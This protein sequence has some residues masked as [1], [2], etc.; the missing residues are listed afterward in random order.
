LA[1]GPGQTAWRAQFTRIIRTRGYFDQCFCVR[2]D[3]G[4]EEILGE[5]RGH[6][7]VDFPNIMVK[8]SV[9]IWETYSVLPWTGSC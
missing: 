9:Q 3:A 1:D 2:R 4:L 6:N 7:T 8:N 5:V